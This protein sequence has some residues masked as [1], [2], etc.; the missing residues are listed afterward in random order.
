MTI[1][2]P[3]PQQAE[4]KCVNKRDRPNPYERIT[5]V[6]GHGKT[7]WKLTQ[8]DAIRKIESG[9][10]IFFVALSGSTKNVWVEIGISRYGNKYLRTEGDSDERNNLLSLPECL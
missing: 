4:I 6:G 5:H 3:N 8:E 9:E 2:N 10:W 1:P 7:A